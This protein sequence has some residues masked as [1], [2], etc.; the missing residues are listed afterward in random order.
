MSLYRLD[1]S[2]RVEGS[3]SRALADLVEQ[4]WRNAHPDEQVIRRHVGVDPIPATAWAAAVFAGRTPAPARTDEQ[5]AALALAATL[6]DE[7]VAADAL[8]FAVPLY[9]F[10]VSQ[11]FKTWADM[12]ITDPRM[13][14]GTQPILA[15]KPAVLVTV[16]GGNY[17][18][19]TPR[20]GWDHAT[21]WMQRILADVWHLDLNVVQAEFTNVGVNPALDR[22]TELARELRHEAE[23]QARRHGRA[24][25][26]AVPSTL[27]A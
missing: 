4:E 19:G 25:G 15:G 18:P 7:L 1:A 9:N 20:E 14:A 12:V 11:H 22:F 21:G 27:A 6:T 16:R 5:R 23:G 2:I 10:G 3:H 13:A 26:A 24:L 17:R 8:L